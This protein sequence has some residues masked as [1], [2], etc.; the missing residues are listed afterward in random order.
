LALLL[1]TFIFANS[2]LQQEIFQTVQISEFMRHGARTTWRSV[3][4]MPLTSQL[5]LGNLT[6]NGMRMHF[7]LGSQLRKNYP[8][9]FS[10]S[11]TNFDIDL[12]TSS[13]V[14]TISSLQSHML[15]MFPLGVG[16]ELTVDT[17]SKFAVPPFKGAQS[18]LTNSS[19]LP[20]AYRPLPYQILSLDQ[21]YLFMPNMYA[22]CAKANQL[23]INQRQAIYSKYQPLFSDLSNQVAAAGYDSKK[24]VGTT[25]WSLDDL[26][27]VHD[28]FNSY[29]NYFGKLPD[30]VSDELFK[31]LFQ[32]SNVNFPILQPD[33]R[34][35]R[36]L[37]DGMARN[38]V[39]GM[40]DFITGKLKRKVRV[41]S[42]HDTGLYSHYLLLNLTDLQCNLDIF[43][44]GQAS[45]PCEE[46]PEFASSFLY[47][48]NQKTGTQDY[49]VRTLLSGKPI[50][51]CDQ[52]EQQY[53]CK[54]DLFKKTL[55]EK[56]FFDPDEFTS[57]CG[58]P[59]TD[60]YNKNNRS[61]T[62][63]TVTLIILGLVLI[64]TLTATYFLTKWKN[65]M[66]ARADS[67]FTEV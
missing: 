3:L 37:A 55:S 50:V 66:N 21:D 4:N 41:F 24:Y 33:D 54:Y 11:F 6:S 13:N 51:I 58:N 44:K 34:A 8:S 60:I 14:R 16:E 20:R 40:E 19:A 15:G 2:S 46:S 59:L 32:A 63:I 53:Y 17:N 47:E 28:E 56:L 26:S 35:K 36:A 9:I 67:K 12:F 25:E 18:A 39:Q 65:D 64:A 22:Y 61:T 30:G 57:Y 52:N 48:L 43:T 23:V 49:Y 10:Q 62:I 38:V 5:G 31:K 45:R 27:Q 29:K 42:G 7:L 1:V